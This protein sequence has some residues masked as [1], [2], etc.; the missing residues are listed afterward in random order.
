MTPLS[1]PITLRT[2]RLSSAGRLLERSMALSQLDFSVALVMGIAPAL[3]VLYWSLRRFD[4]PFTRYR[5]FDDRRVFGGLAVGLIFGAVA[6]FIEV[7][8]PGGFYGTVFALVAFLVFEESFKMVWLN[9]KS[10]R[11]R[12]DTTFYGVSIG[13]GTA[14]MLVVANVLAYLARAGSALYAPENIVL[15]AL[16]SVSLN[17]VQTDTGVMIGFGASRGEMMWPFIKA[18]LVRLAHTLMLLAFSLGLDEP[19]SAIAVATSIVFAAVLYH[20]V[21]TVLLP[22]TLPDDVKKEMQREKRRARKVKA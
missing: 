15:F 19:W 10:Y 1:A 4:I 16:F 14:A 9:R 8:P 2:D 13:V 11:G 7:N 5:L 12:F 21:Y 22:A 3:A 18:V 20:Y 17:L 6:A